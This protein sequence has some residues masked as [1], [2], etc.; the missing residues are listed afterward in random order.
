M[1]FKKIGRLKNVFHPGVGPTR[2]VT[3][4]SERKSESVHRRREQKRDLPELGLWI[5]QDR[6][7]QD[8]TFTRC[9]QRRCVGKLR[10]GKEGGGPEDFQC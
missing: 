7:R 2:I 4:S 9:S 5:C 8:A 3:C 6:G 1:K 10:S